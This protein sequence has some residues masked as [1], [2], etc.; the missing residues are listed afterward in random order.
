VRGPTGPTAAG[1][2]NLADE[3][4]TGEELLADMDAFGIWWAYWPSQVGPPGHQD[5]KCFV[6]FQ[7]FLFEVIVL[8]A[9]QCGVCGIRLVLD[10][11]PLHAHQRP[12]TIQ[13]VWSMTYA[14]D[15]IRLRFS[16]VSRWDFFSS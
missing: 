13:I 16:T 14:L 9:F 11:I 4:G 10:Y 7:A 12:F 6:D 15:W 2:S 1:W 5:G 8:E 3:P